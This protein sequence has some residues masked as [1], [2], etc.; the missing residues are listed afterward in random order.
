MARRLPV[1]AAQ[2]VD[3]LYRAI[4]RGDGGEMGDRFRADAFVFNPTA[5]GVLTSAQATVMDLIGW[6]DAVN[7]RGTV[8]RLR[9]DSR[10]GGVNAE[11][12]AAW[13]FDQLTAEVVDQG[14]VA[15]SV[16]IRMTALMALADR[17]QVAAAYWSIPYDTQA[18]QDRVKA[19]GELPA[20][21]GLPEGV[22]E[23]ARPFVDALS[24]AL[25]RPD[26]LPQLYSDEDDHVTIGSVVDEVFL[27]A[28]GRAAWREFVRHVTEFKLRGPLRAELV[29]PDVGWLAANIEV[30]SPPTPYRFF[31]IWQFGLNGWQIT[32][33]HDAV[34]RDPLDA[35]DR[36]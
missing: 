34:S 24:S 7:A 11:G 31:Y 10:R 4:E 2:S 21:A 8:L 25:A 27:G 30:G 35:A 32:V 6:F 22:A 17:W 18:E 16:A 29:V 20:G 14:S 28:A 23:V 9:I 13:L 36:Q 12:T 33:Q 15:C 3:E 1:L 5:E 26:L 19:A